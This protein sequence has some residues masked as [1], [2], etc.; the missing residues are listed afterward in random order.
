MTNALT[1]NPIMIDTAGDTSMIQTPMQIRC[2]QWVDDAADIADNSDL[3]FVIDQAT[4]TLKPQLNLS[5]PSRGVAFEMN[6]GCSARHCNY[7]RVTTIDAGQL[8]IW[9]K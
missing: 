8:L 9:L 5:N 2:I 1:Q 6:F 7:F 4:V 3:V